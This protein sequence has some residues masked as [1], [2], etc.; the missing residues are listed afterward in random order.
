M[1]RRKRE[2]RCGSAQPETI[3][4]IPSPRRTSDTRRLWRCAAHL[5]AAA[6][7]VLVLGAAG[8]G[9]AASPFPFRGG[10]MCV[11]RASG[12]TALSGSGT[13]GVDGPGE[14]RGR[15]AYLLRFDFT[16]R[17]GPV[18]LESH[19]RSW[20]DP[21]DTA[22]LRFTKVETAPLVTH[23]QEVW[24]DGGKRR[25]T[26]MNGAGGAMLT[27][28]PLDDL[29][30]VYYLRTLKLGDGDSLSVARHYNAARDPVTIRVLG[31]GE[32]RVQAGL[33]RAVEVEMRLRNPSRGGGQEVSRI[34]FTDD[35]R[36]LPLRLESKIPLAG[37]V[38]LELQALSR[39]CG[40]VAE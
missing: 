24:M 1:T 7:G 13:L 31:R 23:R 10:E 28:D 33:F 22:S 12:G 34:H 37:N 9:P 4:D 27:G 5:P 15:E 40:V 18:H 17:V 26:G 39:T 25:W 36:R 32:L 35:A 21:S 38:V 3:P 2:R 8:P 19:S 11:Y 29:S 14:L 30:L 6:A 20:L 16:G